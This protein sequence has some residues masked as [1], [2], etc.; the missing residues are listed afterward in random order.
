ME[1][2]VLHASLNHHGLL[3]VLHDAARNLR[4][5]VHDEGTLRGAQSADADRADEA[6][7]HHERT[8]CMGSVLAGWAPPAGGGRV[9]V[10]GLGAGA[11]AA[12]ARPGTHVTFFERDPRVATLAADPTLFT[13][14]SRC[15]GTYEIVLGD[16]REHLGRVADGAFDLLVVDARVG[17]E[18]ASRGALDLYRRTLGAAGLLVLQV[19]TSCAQV[20][21]PDE[22]ARL[23]G[24]CLRDRA[25]PTPSAAERARGKV[26]ARC[27]VLAR[28]EALL[29][30]LP[31]MAPP[32]DEPPPPAPERVAEEVPP[33]DHER[34]YPPFDGRA[35][36]EVKRD[37][38][39]NLRV[40]FCEGIHHG[41]QSLDPQRADQPASY[42]DRS[43]PFGD[44]FAGWNPR[45]RAGHAGIIGL[46][47]GCMAAF[48]R[49][50]QRFTFF[51]I[52]PRMEAIARDPELFTWLSRCRGAVDVV[53]GDG[54]ESLER[55][56]DGAFDLIVVDAFV[57]STIPPHLLSSDALSAYR[58]KI[59]PDGL[60]A[61][62]INGD[63]AQLP[64]LRQLAREAGMS[65]SD[66]S[67][68]GLSEAELAR[69]KDESH[70]AVLA[71]DPDV[72]PWLR[73]DPRWTTIGPG[74]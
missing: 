65:C 22:L 12:Y 70:V 36:L 35:L 20:P 68:L 40:L 5:M 58:R 23:A 32:P 29:R 66:R 56:A 48:A 18:L 45:G 33:D 59:G 26:R 69:G 37:R 71:R 38:A 7:G 64:M 1:H 54:R 46:G 30:R 24:L 67:D 60:I 50:G 44:L 21:A 6:L 41:M 27:L 19:D 2:L 43:G 53:L 9:G 31:E 13:Y 3:Q 72:V 57:C 25:D 17:E 73:D 39:R 63:G 14:L 61:F 4:V 15:Q 42:Y 34:F 52:D 28:D 49:P 8:G 11:L 16:E 55:S 47:A 51:E 74:A 10:V 62:H